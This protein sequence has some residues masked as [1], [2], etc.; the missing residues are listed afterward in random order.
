MEE[1]KKQK[2]ESLLT[3]AN[4]KARHRD[5]DF[6]SATKGSI[7]KA[8]ISDQFDRNIYLHGEVGTG[9]TFLAV[10]YL[11]KII[12]STANPGLMINAVELLNEIR[13][14]FSPKSVIQT[15]EVIEK[16]C[17]VDYLLI[18]DLGAEKGGEWVNETFYLILNRR[19][20]SMN[21]IIVTSN[22]RPENIA[23]KL[24]DRIASR[25]L[26][27]EAVVIE[28]KGADK[29]LKTRPNPNRE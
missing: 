19:Y 6:D 27:H 20:E 12:R 8:L 3:Q 21:P 13:S 25:L 17:Q 29:R 11:K 18:D 28:L 10:A 5:I 2:A 16:Y 14:S 15:E 9:K 26:G 23:E 1:R 24:G 4:F 7:L 22:L